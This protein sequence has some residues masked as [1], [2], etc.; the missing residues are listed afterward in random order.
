VQV[1]SYRPGWSELVGLARKRRLDWITFQREVESRRATEGAKPVLG[2]WEEKHGA[3]RIRF[4]LAEIGDAELDV[5]ACEVFAAGALV[6]AK[7]LGEFTAR[8]TGLL[9]HPRLARVGL[10][11][12]ASEVGQIV[13]RD[14]T[15]A[16]LALFER[17]EQAVPLDLERARI[18]LRTTDDL[19]ELGQR[20]HRR[21][22]RELRPL[23]G[24]AIDCIGAQGELATDVGF[25]HVDFALS[26]AVVHRHDALAQRLLVRLDDRFAGESSVNELT[27]LLCLNMA[28]SRARFAGRTGDAATFEAQLRL[29][30]AAVTPP[31]DSSVLPLWRLRYLVRHLRDAAESMGLAELWSAC[32]ARLPSEPF[33]RSLNG[34]SVRVGRPPPD[35][36]IGATL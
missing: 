28:L 18:V 20:D 5:E 21:C 3:A 6:R 12:L 22:M 17:F 16:M 10:L 25:D 35:P 15:G 33:P 19:R 32:E 23:L 11:A 27:R 36:S 2:P 8:A 24:R 30:L 9:S 7:E 14:G 31:L 34:Q 26:F 29:A 1:L 13:R 4:W